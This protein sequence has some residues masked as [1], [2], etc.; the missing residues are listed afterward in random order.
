MAAVAMTD[1]FWTAK[2]GEGHPFLVHPIHNGS[3]ATRKDLQ[4]SHLQ[5]ALSCDIYHKEYWMQQFHIIHTQTM[6][7]SGRGFPSPTLNNPFIQ[8]ITLVFRAEQ[9]RLWSLM[10]AGLNY[11]FIA[12]QLCSEGQHAWCLFHEVAWKCCINSFCD[13]ILWGILIHILNVP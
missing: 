5:G 9:G 4:A 13:A 11:P 2:V 7:T 8:I 12:L 3:L 10:L 1:G 6:L